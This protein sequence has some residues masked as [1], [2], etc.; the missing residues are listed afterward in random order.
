MRKGAKIEPEVV[1]KIKKLYERGFKF[2]DIAKLLK[3]NINT[4]RKYAK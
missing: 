3:L 2:T 4:V 1:E